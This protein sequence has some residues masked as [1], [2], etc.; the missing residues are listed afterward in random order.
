MDILE[1]SKVI[2]LPTV[3][4]LQSA[5]NLNLFINIFDQNMVDAELTIKSQKS[6]ISDI[7]MSTFDQSSNQ[8]DNADKIDKQSP[9]K[10]NNE[11][12]EEEK[13][14]YFNLVFIKIC[15]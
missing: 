13:G 15:H 1:N 12:K 2:N 4:I 7:V 3:S 10:V 11:F 9:R 8:S 14:N 5:N 6:A